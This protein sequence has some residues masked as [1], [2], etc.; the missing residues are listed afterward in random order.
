MP[1]RRA[2]DNNVQCHTEFDHVP[3]CVSGYTIVVHPYICLSRCRQCQR[4]MPFSFCSLEVLY[5]NA[6]HVIL[7]LDLVGLG[8]SC[9][10]I[11]VESWHRLLIRC[12]Y[13]RRKHV[14][15]LK[16]G[17]TLT[18][19]F[20]SGPTVFRSPSTS[21]IHI[22]FRLPLPAGSLSSIRLQTKSSGRLLG[23][24]SNHLNHIS[25]VLPDIGA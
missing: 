11:P 12:K 3:C 22:V 6:M 5:G 23:T 25:A 24:S 9:E 8:L 21:S 4:I 15:F 13:P 14:S 10:R 2:V 18:A 19:N 20:L 16:R 17:E 7:Y 1:Y